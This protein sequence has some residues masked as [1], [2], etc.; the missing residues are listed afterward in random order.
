MT[1]NQRLRRL[2]QRVGDPGC[3]ACRDR[4]GH[5]VM[6]RSRRL[7]DGTTLPLESEPGPCERCGEVA[8]FIIE[9]VETV[10]ESRENVARRAA[11]GC[12][13]LT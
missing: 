2:E 4:R 13:G 7:P 6:V 1:I 8:E 9:I 10:V 3:P 12:P 11:E 5:T